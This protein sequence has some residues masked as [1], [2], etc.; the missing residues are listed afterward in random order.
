VERLFL[1]NKLWLS[2]VFQSIGY[3][4]KNFGL[5]WVDLSTGIFTFE[6]DQGDSICWLGLA[7]D[8]T[9]G[10]LYSIDLLGDNTLVSYDP[11][12]HVQ[13][14]IGCTGDICGRGMCYD[15]QHGILYA[16]MCEGKLY[17]IDKTSG[18][19]SF[20]GNLP[21]EMYLGGLAYDEIDDVIWAITRLDDDGCYL[22]KVDPYTAASTY[23]GDIGDYCIDNL[24]WTC[25]GAIPAPGAIIL[26][27]L[28]TAIVSHLR[29]KKTI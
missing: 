5:G 14:N 29:R 18:A 26:A 16:T 24:A 23:V 15:N 4:L 2:D 28:G 19:A 17:S 7:A 27:G 20:I 12:S 3:E 25:D 22:Y 8:Q 13:T 21:F 1:N 6:H 9:A 11:V 10:I